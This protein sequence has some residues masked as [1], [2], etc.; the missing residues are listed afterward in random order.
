MLLS[1]I[2]S[3]A[4]QIKKDI[5]FVA[6]DFLHIEETYVPSGIAANSIGSLP[7]GWET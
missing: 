4:K 7:V 3:N 1:L 5:K 2:F 6:W